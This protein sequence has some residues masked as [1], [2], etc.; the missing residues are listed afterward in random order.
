MVKGL[1]QRGGRWLQWCV[2]VW[3]CRMVAGMDGRLWIE[4]GRMMVAAAMYGMIKEFF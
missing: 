4:G 1:R 3:R 2:S